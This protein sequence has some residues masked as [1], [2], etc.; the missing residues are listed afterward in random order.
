MADSIKV[1]IVDD[2]PLFR[3]FMT[4]GLSSSIGIEVIGTAA[5]AAEARDKIL[6]LRPDVV[7]MDVEM[8]G[9]SGIDFLRSFLPTHPV[10]VI[11]ITSSPVSALDAISVGALDFV[12]KPASNDKKDMDKF[13]FRLTST[14]RYA[15][16]AK[17]RPPKPAAAAPKAP[18]QP[19]SLGVQATSAKIVA[20]GASTGGPDALA[21]VVKRFPA[22][23]PP[24]VITQH[25]PPTFT[26]LFAERLDRIS[27]MSAK[28]AEDGDRL[29][30]GLII[31][32]AGGKQMRVKRDAKGYYITSRVE[33]KVSGHCP[34]VDVLF[35]SV[36]DAAGKNAVA[37]LL[38]G[39]GADGAEGLLK[40]RQVGAF[41]IGQDEETSVVYGM[42]AVA[43]KIGAVA[44]QLPLD[45]IAEQ[46]VA[47]I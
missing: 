42:P 38:T 6:K 8:P 1:L 45:K 47:K 31:V 36:A 18:E 15:K 46:I 30:P 44:L 41:T 29:V 23:M 5:D 21:Q 22:N 37:A 19:I 33:E 14:M 24:V 34:S 20:L 9:M 16:N 4:N 27:Q 26:K 7:T 10:P 11:V 32:A 13:F 28:E 25:M 3:S 40:L 39:M 43:Q 12:R 35:S 2:S 17:I